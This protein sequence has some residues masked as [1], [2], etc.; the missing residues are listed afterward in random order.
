MKE[1]KQL[2]SAQNDFKSSFRSE[3]EGLQEASRPAKDRSDEVISNLAAT[4]QG[5]IGQLTANQEQ[6]QEAILEQQN[7]FK[8]EIIQQINQQPVEQAAEEAVEQA[9]EQ[10]EGPEDHVESHEDHEEEKDG[11][12]G[13]EEE[14][15]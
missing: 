5:L 12:A 6:M 11:E 1:L 8:E 9:D 10:E 13:D 3:I 14:D 15:N 4:M 7:I 2:Q